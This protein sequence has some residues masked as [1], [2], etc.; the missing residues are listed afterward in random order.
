MTALIEP[1]AYYDDFLDYYKKAQTQQEL[2]NLGIVPHSDSGVGDALM[3]TIELYDV[4]ERKYAGFS[5]IVNDVFYGW[6]EKHPYWTKM[7]AGFHTKERK[8]VAKR[9]KKKHDVKTWLYV[10]LLHR[11]TGSAIN[12][13][14]IP[15]GY[16]NT[17]LFDLH[18]CDNIA[19]MVDV[20][21]SY[22]KPFYTS[23]G[24]QFPAFPKPPEAVSY[25]HLTLPTIY[26]V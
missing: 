9:W 3:E 8:I 10:F 6:T 16:H 24:Y 13:A 26:S 7:D 5:Q 19:E 25:T 17:L 20:M 4:V 15:S 23:I 21:R 12:Y 14:K 18:E 2:C 11:V 1:T 22:L